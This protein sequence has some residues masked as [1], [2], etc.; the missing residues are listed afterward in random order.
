MLLDERWSR[1]L[2]LGWALVVCPVIGWFAVMR[3]DRL[4]HGQ[5]GA[6]GALL[7][8]TA[9][10][11]L[12]AIAGNA[13]LGRRGWSLVISA[14]LAAIICVAGVALFVII[15]LLTLSPDFN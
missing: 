4:S 8:L 2:G 5:L 11:G 9:L 15:L 12:I 1:R 6:V 14:V 3:A 10:P 7:V 13:V